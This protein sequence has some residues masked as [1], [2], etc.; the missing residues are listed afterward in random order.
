MDSCTVYAPRPRHPGVFEEDTDTA[1]LSTGA[2]VYSYRRTTADRLLGQIYL[3]IFKA[4]LCALTLKEQARELESIPKENHGLST[5]KK[6]G[7]AFLAIPYGPLWGPV[8]FALVNKWCS[9]GTSGS[10]VALTKELEKDK[11]K[12]Q[13]C[14]K[15]R[16][17]IKQLHT[18]MRA[19]CP[20]KNSEDMD[21]FVLVE[22]MKSLAKLDG[23]SDSSCTDA[24][25]QS[26]NN[27]KHGEPNFFQDAIT[28]LV[29]LLKFFDINIDIYQMSAEDSL[30]SSSLPAAI[31][32]LKNNDYAAA[33]K[34]LQD[35]SDHI[36][37]TT[38]KLQKAFRARLGQSRGRQEQP[39]SW[40]SGGAGR[41]VELQVLELQVE[42]A[43]EEGEEAEDMKKKKTTKKRAVKTTRAAWMSLV[44]KRRKLRMALLINLVEAWPR[45]DEILRRILPPNYEFFQKPRKDQRGGGV[46]IVFSNQLQCRKVR[47]LYKPYPRYEECTNFSAEFLLLM[48]EMSADFSHIIVAGDFNLWVDDKKKR[49]GR[50]FCEILSD[51]HLD[52]FVRSPTCPRGGH[53]LD[54][55][56]GR[57]MKVSDLLVNDDN[58]SDHW[59][60]YFVA[61][62]KKKDEHDEL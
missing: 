12:Y 62:P 4:E 38:K 9:G 29:G 35:I 56:I 16:E 14:N 10:S 8:L 32:N 19:E 54:L 46:A 26:I 27:L 3:W 51:S 5:G 13:K 36:L 2:M 43:A 52:Q 11:T 47:L 45:G 15:I 57:E 21:R 42:V 55:V 41:R 37:E 17:K 61:K 59:T 1:L 60:V 50:D 40:E 48:N 44:E 30:L 23:L 49:S 18:K 25:K 24:I 53:I 34:I 28:Y 7:L 6:I 58:I 22:L 31:N 20:T 39:Q 33:I